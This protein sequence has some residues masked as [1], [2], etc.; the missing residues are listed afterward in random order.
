[1]LRSDSNLVDA[2]QKRPYQVEIPLQ[3]NFRFV[4]EPVRARFEQRFVGRDVDIQEL[5][6]RI[7]FSEGGSFLITGYRGV[8]KTSFVNQ[9]LSW[10]DR[11]TVLLDVQINLARSLSPSELMHLIVRRLYERLIEKNLYHLLRPSLQAKLSLAYQRTSANVI[12]KLSE[13]WERGLELND[14][15]LAR[16]FIPFAPKISAKRSRTVDLETSFLA[17]DDKSAEHDVISISCELAQ[18]VPRQQGRWRSFLDYVLRRDRPKRPIKIVFVFDEMDKLDEHVAKEAEE[19]AVDEMLSGLKN[20]FTTSGISFLFVAGKDLHER[21]LKDLWSGDSIYESVFSYDKYLGCMWD[22]VDALCAK[23]TALNGTA[24]SK[25]Q[26][27]NRQVVFEKFKNYL[28]FKGRGIPRR[29]LRAFNEMVSWERGKPV[30]AFKNEDLRRVTFF[31]ELNGTLESHSERLF[32]RSGEDVSGTRQDRRKLGI[33]YVVDWVLRQGQAEFTIGDLLTASGHLS[34]RIALAEK[35]APSAITELLEVLVENEYVEVVKPKLDEVAIG[36]D[37]ASEQKLYRMAARRLAEISDLGATFEEEATVFAAPK[38]S[39][40]KKIG[41]FELHE[42]L[43][44]GGMGKVYRAWD[45]ER[46]VFVAL[47]VLHHWLA[48]DPE[49]RE[50]FRR[51]FATLK[52]L[53]HDNIVR[54]Y[55]AGESQEDAFLAMEL[56]DGIDVKTIIMSCGALEIETALALLL[57]TARA[58]RYAHD[59]GFVRLDIKPSNIMVN[60]A[61]H[62]YLADVGIAKAVIPSVT[63]ITQTGQ[64]IGTPMYLAPEQFGPGLPDNRSD[65]Y[66]FGVVLYEVVTGSAPFQS[67]S[68][69]E[70]IHEHLHEQPVP[71]STLVQVSP[72]FD[73]VVLRCLEKDPN[74]RFQNIAEVAEALQAQ[75]PVGTTASLASLVATARRMRRSREEN[76][77]S[78]TQAFQLVE[79]GAPAKSTSAI[80]PDLSITAAGSEQPRPRVPLPRLVI[81]Q[82][83]KTVSEIPLTSDDISIGRAP[84]SMI[85]LKDAIG[86]SRYHARIVR[87]GDHF[88]LADL[89]SNNGTFLNGSRVFDSMPL[90]DQ[91]VVSIGDV[92]LLFR[93]Q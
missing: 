6:H 77:N 80:L 28:R 33:Y 76:Q 85:Q 4:H 52:A 35:V 2:Q 60:T 45:S 72:E 67:T 73:S 61:G 75:G 42:T 82:P 47:K 20:L 90:A 7:R 40:N 31:A 8:G 5:V 81:S 53:R 37:P 63:A 9:V 3:D 16:H 19:S 70:L 56:I 27:A 1:M 65:I 17:Y 71:P 88:L 55:E 89:N 23:L 46:N 26:D 29:I 62:V 13:G 86:V 83:G 39:T 54:Y 32:E 11:E 44:S 14:L 74:K 64:L 25:G 24:P 18:G 68:I 12:R 41:R 21:W 34:A 57:P 51:E 92:Q 15:K 10:L 93:E 79:A 84:D 36:R 78:F 48:A 59:Q 66:A 22:D 50:R 87:E 58:V 38:G 30:L 49:A 43:G 91:D 69:A